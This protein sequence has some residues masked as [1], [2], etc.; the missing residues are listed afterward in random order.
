MKDRAFLRW[1]AFHAV[2]LT[3]ALVLVWAVLG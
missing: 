2:S 3:I 1:V